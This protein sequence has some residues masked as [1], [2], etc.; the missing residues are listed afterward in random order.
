MILRSWAYEQAICAKAAKAFSAANSAPMSK[1]KPFSIHFSDAERQKLEREAGGKALGPS[2]NR[3]AMACILAALG[4]SD[5]AAPMREIPLAAQAGALEGS[6]DLRLSI[7]AV[8]PTI[9]KKRADLV[10]GLELNGQELSRDLYRE[11]GWRIPE[12]HADRSITT[13]FPFCRCTPRRD[14]LSIGGV[15]R[16]LTKRILVN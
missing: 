3:Q 6:D 10:R 4:S 5:L 12:G 8:C 16:D 15:S 2:N 13:K 11:H 7:Q 9:E 1:S 14:E